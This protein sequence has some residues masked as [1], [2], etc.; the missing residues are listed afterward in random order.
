MQKNYSPIRHFL[1][2]A[3]L[4][5]AVEGATMLTLDSVMPEHVARW[6]H[7]A[8]DASVMMTLVAVFT[9]RLF[10]T[11]LRFAMLSETA[12]ATAV[13]DDA[14]D[15]V[16]TL[17]KDGTI[18]SCN[19]AAERMFGY[20]SGVLTSKNVKILMPQSR[21]GDDDG[22][23]A[24]Y[25]R[26]GSG[27]ASA[28]HGEIEALRKDGTVFPVDVSLTEFR[29]GGLRRFTCIIRDI[30]ERKRAE[31]ELT[32]SAAQFRALVEQSIAGISIVQ[33]GK[34]VYVNPRYAQILG[35]G[36]AEELIDR[37]M[38]EV[39]VEQDR[40]RVLENQRAQIEGKMPSLS[41]SYG[42]PKKDG[43]TVEIG[44]HGSAATYRGRLAII[45]LMQDIS[46]KKR[47][48]D[49]IK[50]YVA[51]LEIAFMSTVKVATTL[52][53][54]RD[55]YTA[56]HQRR[57]G[58]IAVAIGAELGFDARRQEGLRVAG[59]LHDIGKITI[60]AEILSKPSKL[61]AIEYQ[62]IQGHPQSGYEVLKGVEFPWPVAEVALQ[63]H[64]R[65]DGS[66]YPQGL[67]GEAIL[68]ESR[69]MAVADVVEAMST[70][71]PYRAGL[72][73]ENALAEIERGRGSA[74]D[75][76]VSDACLRLFREKHYQLP[77]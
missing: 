28:R 44:V 74:Y 50:R 52:G 56:G 1:S 62:L 46:E 60:P 6:I 17:A 19:P 57:V 68:L 8:I 14:I 10:I 26:K 59:Y 11:P 32:E 53:E 22:Y 3:A 65:I 77:A 7:A 54:M 66:G 24:R 75:L 58:E 23:F 48:E 42:A 67:K 76:D 38:T 51:Q 16:I 69:I 43:S 55:P 70:H 18:E 30:T 4:V 73:I 15:A 33:D 37:D 49:E 45:G 61:N 13:L 71:R 25:V 20:Q 9:W 35:H 47:S 63:H 34:L 2:L 64:E 41:Y 72:G 39:V 36:S 21:T 31:L 12:Q 29:L 27:Q 40:T 5:F